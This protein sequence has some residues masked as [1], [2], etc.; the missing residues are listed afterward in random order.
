[1]DMVFSFP[2]LPIKVCVGRYVNLG[3]LGISVI[4]NLLYTDFTEKADLHGFFQAFS[5]QIQE[6]RVICVQ[7]H[8]NSQ[9]A[10][11]F[12]PC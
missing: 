10:L 1:M 12:Y 3:S 6:I 2:S 7:N 9:R 11:T 5:V 4:Q 8:G